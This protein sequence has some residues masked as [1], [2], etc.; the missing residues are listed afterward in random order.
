LLRS[1]HQTGP[2]IFVTVLYL[3]DI[4]EQSVQLADC[5]VHTMDLNPKPDPTPST[6]PKTNRS[7]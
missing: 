2:R 6:N 7:D 4:I 5:T 1:V 3:L